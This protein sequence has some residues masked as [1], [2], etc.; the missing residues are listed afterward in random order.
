MSIDNIPLPAFLYQKI[1]GKNLV[2]LKPVISNNVLNK[3]PKIDFLGGNEKKIIFL[4]NDHQNKFLA[5]TQMKFLYELLTAC[6]L[7][8]GETAIVNFFHNSTITYR[9]L[10]LQLQPKKILMFGVSANDLNIPFTIPFF[11]MQNFGEQ[12]Y[13]LSP[14]IEELQL[15]KELRKQLWACLQKIFNIRKQK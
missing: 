6:G 9:E 14:A 2:D 10:M 7:T 11:Q 4:V 15:N 8:M 12:V 13:M 3:E 1:F 5:D